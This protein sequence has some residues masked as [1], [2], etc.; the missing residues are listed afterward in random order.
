MNIGGWCGIIS[1]S[2]SL[3]DDF[4]VQKMETTPERIT[5]EIMKLCEKINENQPIYIPVRPEEDALMNECFENVRIT[6]EKKGGKCVNGWCIW[7]MANILIEAEAHSIW[8]NENG[9]LIDVTPH[10]GNE[11]KILFLPDSEL[12]FNDEN[13]GNI[14]MPLTDSKLVKEYIDL[15]EE[16]F[17]ILQKYKPHEKINLLDL[18][19]R[20]GE[21]KNRL[22][23]IEIRFHTKVGRNDKCPCDSGLKYKKCCGK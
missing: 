22:L 13:I 1:L 10:D 14:R 2:I 21:I 20:Y 19:K 4:M 15:H 12:V 17:S 18:P 11:S 16:M 5:D 8:Q 3:G 9:E 6:V 7:K 23:T